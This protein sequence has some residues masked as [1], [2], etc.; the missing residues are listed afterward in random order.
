[1]LGNELDSSAWF[2][3]FAVRLLPPSILFSPLALRE[4]GVAG[5]EGGLAP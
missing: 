2:S 4:G 5:A 3:E 1:M